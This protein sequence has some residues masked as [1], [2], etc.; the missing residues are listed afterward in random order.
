MWAHLFGAIVQRLVC[1]W[2]FRAKYFN[3]NEGGP[4]TSYHWRVHHVPITCLNHVSKISNVKQA[5]IS[6]EVY[7]QL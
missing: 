1:V 6:H 2:L 4:A 3:V 5:A 7:I